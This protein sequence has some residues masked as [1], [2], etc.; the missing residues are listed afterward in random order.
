M[1]MCIFRGAVG[2]G[3]IVDINVE[4]SMTFIEGNNSLKQQSM[5]CIGSILY[6]LMAQ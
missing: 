6:V 3:K 4:K 1:S 2:E 5:L